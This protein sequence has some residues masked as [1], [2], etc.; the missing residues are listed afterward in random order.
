MAVRWALGCAVALGLGCA[1]L[2]QQPGCTEG[3]H[4]ALVRSLSDGTPS[5]D[6]YHWSTCDTSWYHG[7]FYTAKGPGLAFISLPLYELLRAADVAWNHLPPS[8]GHLHGIPGSAVWPFTVFAVVL[9]AFGLFLLARSLA[10]RVVPGAGLA[11]AVLLTLGTMLLP[12]ATLFSAQVPAAML[13]FAAFAVLFRERRGPRSNGRLALGGCL[14]GLALVFDL[15][16]GLVGV[17]L[18]G[19]A[20]AGRLSIARAGSYAAGALVGVLPLIAFNQWAFGSVLH[21]SY[22][23]TVAI[24]GQTGHDQLGANTNGF[25]GIGVPSLNVAARLLLLNHGLLVTTPVIAAAVAGLVPMVRDRSLG[26]RAEGALIT[27]LVVAYFV[28]NAGY[29]QPFGGDSAGPRFLL[30][31]IPFLCLPLAI[32]LRRLPAVVA[33]LGVVSIA[34][35]VLATLTQPMLEADDTSTWF[36]RAAHGAFQDTLLTRAGVAS[37]AVGVVPTA[38]LW[39]AVAVVGWRSI[40][41]LSPLRA[42]VGAGAVA[43]AAWAIVASVAPAILTGGMAR[44]VSTLVALALLAAATAATVLLA[45]RYADPASPRSAAAASSGETGTT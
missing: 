16:L 31:F 34:M 20:L 36:T 42:S 33:G 32:V 27:A 10:E 9:S 24:A 2:V 43:L 37:H 8:D 19:Y 15:P 17:A 39:L 21:Q 30:P 14:A 41:R 29:Y 23:D 25:F 3:G 11:V 1:L 18:F 28:Y 12:Y 35:M 26:L 5:I 22:S 40:R 38:V 45:R 6:R 4:Y 44:V 13:G 7:H